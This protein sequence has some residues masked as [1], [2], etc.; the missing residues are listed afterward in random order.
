MRGTRRLMAVQS[1]TVGRGN[2]AAWAMAGMCSNKFVEPP[3]AACTAIALRTPPG[4]R[5]S[6]IVTPRAS[7]WQRARAE[8]TAMSVQ[9]GWPEGARAECASAIPSASPTTCDVAAVPRNWHPPPGE[10]QARQ[11]SSAAS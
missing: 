6:R 8:R 10:A 3:N 7:S 9:T 5:I 4:E 11:P 2:P 1:S